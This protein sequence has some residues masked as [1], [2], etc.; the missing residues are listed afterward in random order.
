MKQTHP[1]QSLLIDEAR[2]RFYASGFRK[3]TVD[4]LVKEIRLSKVS[5][6]EI[7]TSKEDLVEYL[8]KES[9]KALIGG[10]DRIFKESTFSNTEKL[11]RMTYAR[12]QHL[13][14]ISPL[15][16]EDLRLH[17]PELWKFYQAEDAK[18]TRRYF[19]KILNEGK[20]SGLFR[21]DLPNRF[22]LESFMHMSELLLKTDLAESVNL[23]E[24]KIYRKLMGIFLNGA[25][26]HNAKPKQLDLFG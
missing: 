3:T 6:Y 7:F 18:I 16:F 15:Y 11:I 25:V 2:S 17:H 24:E 1:K 26:D 8:T 9:L 22:L 10:L 20:K 13:S 14:K 23:H 5:F 19:G 12:G 4:Q 21:K